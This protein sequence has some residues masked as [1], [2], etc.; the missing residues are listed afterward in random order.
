[1][2]PF[3]RMASVLWKARRA[4][5]AQFTD[6][7]TCTFYAHPW[8][9]DQFMEMNNGRHLTLYDLGRFDLALKCGLWRVL[10]EQKW[11]L[12]VAGSSVRFR[13]RI[14]MFQKVTMRT[15]LIGM[16]HRWFYIQQSMEVRG[17]PC[18]TAL[19]RTGITEKGRSILTERVS[20]AMGE[21]GFS[22]E[23]PKWV[24]DWIDADNTRPWPPEY[25]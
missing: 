24:Q 17:E 16:D 9:M 18:S 10:K 23:P 7:T 4:P 21:D 5:A 15:Q 25:L 14:F 20:K 19:F 13:K 2:Y 12:V 8:D 3:A 6:T 22:L 1:M 11:G